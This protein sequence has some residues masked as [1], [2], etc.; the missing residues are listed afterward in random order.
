[1]K[2]YYGGTPIK[3]LNVRHYEL[4]TNDATVQPSDLQSGVTCYARGQK[5][6]GTGKAFEFA[7]YGEL[8]TNVPD[9]TP[10]SI[11][12]IEIASLEYPIRSSYALNDMKDIDFSTEQTI[13]F[14]T[15]DGVEYPITAKVEGVLITLGCEKT[16]ALEIF[17]GR[18]RYA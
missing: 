7:S 4:S 3:S 14:V 17:Y 9:Y 6:T 1:M 18:D 12:V 16:I 15:I 11:N 5:I 2:M 10:V 13:G 8:E